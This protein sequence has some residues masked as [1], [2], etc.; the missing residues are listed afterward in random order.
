MTRPE[1]FGDKKDAQISGLEI[2][3]KLINNIIKNPRDPKFRTINRSNKS[4]QSKLLVVQPQKTLFE[5]LEILGYVDNQE[6]NSFVF[7]GEYFMVL[8]RGF[9]FI[10]EA[11]TKLK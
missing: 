1:I 2:L 8:K 6:E 9:A 11:I 5:M 3:N 4:I 10:E 7:V